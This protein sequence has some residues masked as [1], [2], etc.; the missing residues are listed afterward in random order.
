M[1]L[2]LQQMKY[3]NKVAEAGSLT[4]AAKQLSVSQAAL[5]TSISQL[6]N[7]LGVE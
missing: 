2:T 6:E 7:E 5:S 1:K 4:E 3:V